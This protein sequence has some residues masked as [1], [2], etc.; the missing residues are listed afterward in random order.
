MTH[1]EIAATVIDELGRIAPEIDAGHLDPDVDLREQFDIDSMDFLNLVIALGE[2]LKIEI[3]E[4]DYS[5]LA[6][7]RQA[8]AYLAQKLSAAA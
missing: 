4:T 5:N 8:V 2:R 3:P 1:D 6:T 7:L